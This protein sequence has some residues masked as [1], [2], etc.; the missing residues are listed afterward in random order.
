MLVVEQILRGGKLHCIHHCSDFTSRCIGMQ[1]RLSF[2]HNRRRLDDGG[3]VVLQHWSD[4]G[5][6]LARL[7]RKLSF[8]V[9]QSVQCVWEILPPSHGSW[10]PFSLGRDCLCLLGTAWC[11]KA[12]KGAIRVAYPL[13][14]PLEYL[15]WFLSWLFFKS[16]VFV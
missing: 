15:I 11:I 6:R 14:V 10:C 13:Y 5:G 3:T 12:E 1:G 2:D 7:Q 16:S 9:E 4:R 8:D